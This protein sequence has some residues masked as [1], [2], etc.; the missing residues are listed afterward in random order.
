MDKGTK[1]V[2]VLVYAAIDF[3][4]DKNTGKSRIGMRTMAEK[5]NIPLSK[6]KDA[7]FRLR[8]AGYIEYKQI[9]SP[10]NKDMVFNE[11]SLPFLKDRGGFLMLNPEL[12]TQN[13]NPKERGMLIFLQLIAVPSLND[14]LETK[15]E[16]IASRLKIT[17]QTAS[18]YI[19]CFLESGHIT[20][21]GY[22]YKCRYLAN[23]DDKVD[24]NE[25]E[26]IL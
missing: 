17:R 12:L 23:E 3:H 19:K 1:F 25:F 22:F 11:Y 16:D 9:P 20:K 15:M 24:N 26:I 5:Y 2:D 10:N 18:K 7:V 14:I 4:R 13:L 8:A 6:V 21:G